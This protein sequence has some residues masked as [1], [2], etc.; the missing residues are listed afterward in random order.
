M[1]AINI[2][3]IDENKVEDLQESLRMS[4]THFE[5]IFSIDEV[6]IPTT[7]YVKN[8]IVKNDVKWNWVLDEFS[9][10]N[11]QKE[12]Q[13]WSAVL[14]KLATNNYVI[15]F[16][17]AFYYIDKFSDKN[18]AF[19]IGRKFEYKQ[20]K[21]TAQANPNSNKNK[22]VVSYLNSNY[23][24]YDSGE[25]FIKI[26]GKIKLPEGCNLFKESIEIGSSIKLNIESPSLEKCI[27]ALQYIDNVSLQDDITRIPVFMKVKNP[28]VINILESNLKQKF[29]TESIP[30]IFSDFDIIGTQEVFYS[31]G[32]VFNIRY[33]HRHEKVEALTEDILKEFCTRNNLNY[34]EIALDLRITAHMEDVPNSEH[35]IKEFI[36]YTDDE[37]KCVLI[38]GDWYQY[39]DDY[40]EELNQSLSEFEIFDT[41]EFDWTTTKYNEI[42][43][44]KYIDEK[45]CDE[46]RGKTEQEIRVLLRKK[47][48]AERA[49]NEYLSIHF[50]YTLLDRQF[51][52]YHGTKVEI[53]DLYKD[54]CLIASKIGNSSSKFCYAIEQI[55]FSA[56][57]LKKKLI[58]FNA[59]VKKVA[60]LIVLDRQT[61]LSVTNGK[62]NIQ[63]LNLLVF[64]NKLNEWKRE[65]WHL[66]YEPIL[67]IGYKY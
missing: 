23:F 19:Q 67:Y 35:S 15:T 46:Y 48:Y 25:S 62:I 49:Y 64:K 13:A 9:V 54:E 50:G 66:G 10:D 26:K 63:E 53:A 65:M 56:K 57:C 22:T 43:D 12:K 32:H 14:I 52:E 16:G 40:L 7:L 34:A 44:Q 8:E 59:S 61:R 39:N 30:I 41:P 21:S 58:A 47:Y 37:R 3:K 20:I 24:E 1:S 5:K 6:S 60:I 45:D 31:G 36:D 27:R 11:I 33:G 17:N 4:G 18:F 29:R 42:I 28:D 2:F 51:A 38:K 55:G